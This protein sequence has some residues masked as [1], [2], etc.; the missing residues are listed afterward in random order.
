[1]CHFWSTLVCNHP[2]EEEEEEEWGPKKP[3]E[4]LLAQRIVRRDF[5]L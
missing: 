5:F 4:L 3:N 1:M 2:K